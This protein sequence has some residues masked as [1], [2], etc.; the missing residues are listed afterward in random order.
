MLA[1]PRGPE[2]HNRHDDQDHYSEEE[3]KETSSGSFTQ[4]SPQNPAKQEYSHRPSLETPTSADSRG[5]ERV[6]T[7]IVKDEFQ[8][9]ST[10]QEN[11]LTAMGKS[12]RCRLAAGCTDKILL[13]ISPPVQVESHRVP[14]F[15]YFGPTAIVPGY[16]AMVV[17]V[18][19]REHR[20][21]TVPTPARTFTIPSFYRI[22]GKFPF[23]GF[24]AL[25][26]GWAILDI[27]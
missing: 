20:R 1:I 9:I 16:K 4:R 22:F 2:K 6:D 10:F 18:P 8:G 19:S 14:Y 17:A 11:D 15:R 24:F 25:V 7:G 27:F 3:E 21:S 5:Y 26:Q 23:Q 12:P 13:D